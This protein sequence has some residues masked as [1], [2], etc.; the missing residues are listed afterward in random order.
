MVLDSVVVVCLRLCALP[1]PKS[2]TK[3]LGVLSVGLGLALLSFVCER[4]GI[5]G[6]KRKET[7][8]ETKV[9]VGISGPRVGYVMVV[10]DR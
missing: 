6:S 10:N 9:A 8:V 1:L 4:V 5:R 2:E 7:E 3:E